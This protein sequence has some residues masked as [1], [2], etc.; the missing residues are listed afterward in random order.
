MNLEVTVYP[1]ADSLATDLAAH[2]DAWGEAALRER[3]RFLVTLAGGSTPR[4]VYQAWALSSRLPWTEVELMVGDERCVA[5]EDPA[6]NY[7]MV[8]ESL[9]E[10][11]EVRPVIYRM[12]GEDADPDLGALRFET[13]LRRVWAEAPEI[14]VSLLGIGDDGHTASLFPGAAALEETGRRCVATRAPGGDSRLTLTFPV[15]RQARRRAFV[16]T[17]EGKADIL[18]EVLEGPYDPRRLPVQTLLHDEAL[19]N[20]LFID[21]AAAA[22][23]SRE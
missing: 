3:Q 7:R 15:L 19:E 9:L 6:S 2:L 20:H 11:L 12:P 4:R 5:P 16:A 17:G 14:E 23:L 10:R 18:R 22:R 8:M 1:D 21:E 13:L